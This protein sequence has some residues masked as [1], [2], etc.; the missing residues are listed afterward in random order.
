[1]ERLPIG[2]DERNYLMPYD[3]EGLVLD[4]VRQSYGAPHAA[5]VEL[6]AASNLGQ[7]VRKYWLLVLIFA[8]LGVAGGF[9]SVVL[10][11]PTY[12]SRMLLEIQSGGTV[13]RNGAP[14]GG[15]NSDTSETTIQ[16]QI[17][18]LRSGTFLNRGADRMNQ[19]AVAL[20]PSGRDIFSK[21]RQRIH[22]SSEDPIENSRAALGR[23]MASFNA[24]AVNRTRLIELTCES[25]SP[26]IAAQFLNAMAAEYIDYSTRSRMQTAQRTSEW[27]AQSIEEAKTNM[28]QA[29]ERLR[30]FSIASGNI[31]AGQDATLEDTKLASLKADLAKSQA[32]A[33]AKRTRYELTLKY[34][35]EALGE[36]LDDP[37]LRGH[38]QKINALKEQR[39][40]LEV[41]FTAKHQKVREVDAQLASVEKDYQNEIHDVLSRIKQD[42]E[43][44]N[45]QQQLLTQSYN[46]QAQRVGAQMGKASQYSSLRRDADT[47]HT[48]YQS[49]L[50]QQSEAGLNASVPGNQ[51]QILDAA[52]AP[53]FPAKPQPVVNMALGTLLG[54]VLAGGIA[55][56]KERTD[57]RIRVPGAS[58]QLFNV[59]ELGV[60]PNLANGHSA[61][62][63]RA[64]AGPADL[65]LKA[66]GDE[67]A[68]AL[69]T[70][71]SGPSFITESFRGTL[72]SIL[73]NQNN[74]QARRTILVTSPG[75][76]EGKTT[77]VQNLGIA[78]AETG[79]RVLLVDG[80]FRRPHLHRK[81]GVPNDWGIADLLAEQRPVSEYGADRLGVPTG[82]S[83]L[84]LL[85]NGS[86]LDNVSRSLYS[87]RL[88]EIVQALAR[89][90]DMV[91]LD[92]PP[93][94]GVADTRILA[95]LA[96]ALILVLRSGVTDRASAL[97]AYNRIQEDGLA[98]LGTVLTDYDLSADRKKQYY[99]DYGDPSRA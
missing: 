27:L 73:R 99:Y 50:I 92:A 8:I 33:I 60:I 10:T 95:P 25:S 4:S 14:A 70:W 44:A 64:I 56:L 52:K 86:G 22:P 38:Q 28:Q 3:E 82:F 46:T 19:D 61:G 35:P 94:L 11:T 87:P 7:M 63:R 66:D 81:F 72:T 2:P 89:Q 34:P 57:Q 71:Q 53:E 26:D 67:A 91:L 21:L 29:D 48:V 36:V 74:G 9:A 62:A 17:S 78:L 23:A 41:R 85:V 49:L 83:G 12:R 43:A 88:R 98:L 90:Y 77:V 42:Y 1:M 5:P 84:S 75:P 16:T 54:A 69:V 59:P 13:L 76:S 97:E 80:D 65:A 24:T 40:A 68:A 39:A 45:Q 20:V 15:E 31:F 51:I 79:R 55:F 47:L 93:I 18:I 30:D 6:S 58:R 96:D 32:D 37:S